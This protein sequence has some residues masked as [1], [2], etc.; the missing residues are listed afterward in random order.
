ME[1]WLNTFI[2]RLSFAAILTSPM[3]SHAQFEDVSAFD[4]IAKSVA[5]IE[6]PISGTGLGKCSAAFVRVDA[7]VTENGVTGFGTSA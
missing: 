6:L 5:Q 4:P 7:V 2:G 3:I 1:H